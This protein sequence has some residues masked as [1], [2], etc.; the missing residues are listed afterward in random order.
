M[1][2]DLKSLKSGVKKLG[3]A[4]CESF[5]LRKQRNDKETSGSDMPVLEFTGF[6]D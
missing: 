5:Q 6:S 3:N 2:C 4:E 1:F